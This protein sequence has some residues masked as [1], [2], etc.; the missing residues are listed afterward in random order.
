M[1][2][3]ALVNRSVTF[4]LYPTKTQEVKLL[5]TKTLHKHLYN[6]SL[7][8]RTTEYRSHRRSVSFKAQCKELT[9]LRKADPDY[10]AM[11]AQ[12]EQ[13]T[14]KKVDKAMKAFFTRV[15]QGKT[16]G[17]P[18]FKSDARCPGWS[19]KTHGDGWKLLPG[20]KGKHGRLRLSGIGEVRVRG[21]AR[22][23]GTPKTCT[24]SLRGDKWYA[25]VVF[26]C[27]PVREHGQEELG[28]DWGIDTYLMFD[29]GS[30]IE[31][32]K[33]VR[34]EQA[35][36]AQLQQSLSRK[37]KGSQNYKKV[38]KQLRALHEK[39]A[40]K[41]HNFLHQESKKIVHR[42]A[43]IGTEKLSVKNMSRSAKGTLEKPGK[44]VAQ[45]A[46]LNKS[47]LDGA[48]S[49]LNRLVA[50][51]AAEAGSLFVEAPTR[52]IKPS[53]T[54]PDCGKQVKKT[55]EERIHS[56]SCGCLLPRDQASAIV[57][58]DYAKLIRAGNRFGAVG[59][60]ESIHETPCTLA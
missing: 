33:W 57:C 60:Q 20:P 27:E 11:N 10:A 47:I 12:S 2:M 17:Y 35:H 25:T 45:K 16:P 21:K 9:E 6:A 36:I 46:G 53:Q 13:C 52:K 34:T 23:H 37:K 50:Y 56:C 29:D 49:T 32:P 15:K 38:R 55:L 24:V 14:L 58:R 43:L 30:R 18:R 59:S 41:R 48:P 7:E 5:R 8:Q 1:E 22:N 40:N 44:N 42:A 54:C 39:I 26:S 28:Y 31:N 19:Y 4:R 3:M 51:K